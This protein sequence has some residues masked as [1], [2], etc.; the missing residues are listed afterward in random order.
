M[1]P[2]SNTEEKASGKRRESYNWLS[3]GATRSEQGQLLLKLE[4]DLLATREREGHY[5]SL[6]RFKREKSEE[7]AP[8][9][10]GSPNS[11]KERFQQM[12][13]EKAERRGVESSN[14][15]QFEVS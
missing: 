9:C 15:Y 3:R 13:Q 4:K 6:L 1:L 14:F 7:I 5:R 12:L 8:S 10:S 2:F 11:R